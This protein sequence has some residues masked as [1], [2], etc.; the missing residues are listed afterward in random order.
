MT[1]SRVRQLALLVL[2]AGL[3]T[4][5]VRASGPVFWTV[6]TA[7]EFL[8]G[9]SDGVFVSRDGVV[10]AGPQIVSRLTATPAQIRFSIRRRNTSGRW[11]SARTAGCGSG[12]ATRP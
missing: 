1:G 4:G 8:R 3:L 10:T 9:T 12:R 2:I 6:A 11:P 5:P 7:A